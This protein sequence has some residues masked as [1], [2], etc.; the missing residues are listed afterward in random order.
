MLSLSQIP[1]QWKWLKCTETMSWLCNG[2]AGMIYAD[3][4]TSQHHVYL[5]KSLH[6]HGCLPIQI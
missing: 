2:L 5:A 1:L 4:V 3:A 6:N